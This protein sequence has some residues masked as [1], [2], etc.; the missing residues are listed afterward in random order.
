MHIDD[1]KI[2]LLASEFK[3]KFGRELLGEEHLG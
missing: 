1:S 2:E 3:K